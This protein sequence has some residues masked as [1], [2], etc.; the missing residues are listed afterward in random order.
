MAPRSRNALND[1]TNAVKPEPELATGKPAKK[2]TKQ[3]KVENETLRAQVADLNAA[4]SKLSIGEE[5]KPVIAPALPASAASLVRAPLPPRRAANP[6]VYF[7]RD[8]RVKRASELTGKSAPEAAALIG[9][10]WKATEAAD[11]ESFEREAAADKARYEREFAAFRTVRDAADAERRALE[12]HFH[13]QKVAA[14]LALYDEHTAA[15][16]IAAKKA[17]VAPKADAPKGARTAYILYS[18][19]RRTQL[20]GEGL[21]FAE[22]TRRIADDWKKLNASKSKRSV[23]Q[24][25]RFQK[26]AE[27]DRARFESEKKIWEEKRKEEAASHEEVMREEFEKTKVVAM[28]SYARKTEEKELVKE[29]NRQRIE[30][31]RLAKEEKKKARVQRKADKEAKA[32]LPKKA[33]TAYILFSVAERPGVVER[34][35]DMTPADVMRELGTMWKAA[36]KTTKSKF[37][38]EAAADKERYQSEMAAHNASL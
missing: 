2:T 1:V 10:W 12:A 16:K 15:G 5:K 14:A 19:E 20:A 22:T 3:L 33:R 29:A 13:E 36:D 25:A 4:L 28:K 31:E 17:A 18:G 8:A 24:V 11:R 27:E 23:S 6:Y 37:E 7:M 21:G 38:K 35:P 26:M 34:C 32:L 30:A 9:S